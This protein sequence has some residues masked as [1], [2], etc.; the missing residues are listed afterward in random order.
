MLVWVAI[1]SND[2]EGFLNFCGEGLKVVIGLLTLVVGVLEQLPRMCHSL[3]Y[4]SWPIIMVDKGQPCSSSVLS[5][6][7][8]FNP[9]VPFCFLE[10][11]FESEVESSVVFLEGMAV[12]AC[13]ICHLFMIRHCLEVGG[14]CD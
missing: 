6:V 2:S 14:Y 13:I 8:S 4:F 10:Y 5:I 12:M 11:G 7:I 9:R 3:C 1:V